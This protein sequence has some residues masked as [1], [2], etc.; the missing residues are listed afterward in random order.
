M[1]M[2]EHEYHL[3][4]MFGTL[5]DIALYVNKEKCIFTMTSA[6]FFRLYHW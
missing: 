1:T 5:R 3:R 2:H 4:V 6:N